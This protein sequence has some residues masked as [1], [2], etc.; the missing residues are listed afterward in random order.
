MT[1]VT[2]PKPP[3]AA[4]DPSRPVSGLLIS[5]IVH[6]QRIVLEGIATEAQ[7]AEYIRSLMRRVKRIH[8]QI[9]PRRYRGRRSS[10]GKKGVRTVAKRA[11]ARTAKQKR[12]R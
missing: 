4:Y 11:R 6:L 5:Q 9:E 2:V 10:V 12:T 3:R 1:V 8:P 7:A